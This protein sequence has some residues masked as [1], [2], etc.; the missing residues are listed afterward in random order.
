MSAILCDGCGL[1]ASSEHIAHRLRRIELATRFRPIHIGILFLAEAPPQRL[2][3]YFYYVHEGPSG[4]AGL[5][6]VL[7]E[8]LLEGVG[9]DP[10]GRTDE[11]RLAEFQKRGY[12]LADSRECPVEEIVPRLRDRAAEAD[13][14]DL[15]HRYGPTIIKRIQLSYKPKH[16]ALL[17]TRTRH[18][19]P[20]LQQAGLGPGLLLYQGLPLR[21]P[22]P[23][24]P[25]AQ[26]QFCAGL[27]EL[28]A[29]AA[30][31]AKTASMT[32]P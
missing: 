12:F 14:S 19:I 1:P 25:A 28:L 32:K 8:R 5:S 30:A 15:A 20:L 26:S 27:A 9:I 29:A 7:F 31:R 17:S 4:R 6:Q 3:D 11:A 13:A 24:N 10:Q 22:H 23:H 2:E 18:L 16:V 21:F